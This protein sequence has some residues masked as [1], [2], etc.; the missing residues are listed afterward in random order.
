[1][2]TGLFWKK[3]LLSFARAFVPFFVLGLAGAWDSFVTGDLAAGKSA[4][5]ALVT[6]AITAGLRAAQALFTNLETP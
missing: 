5:I 6:G 3:V 1:M 4:V 2:F